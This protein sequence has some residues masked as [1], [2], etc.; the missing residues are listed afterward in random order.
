M[1]LMV[2]APAVAALRL[3]RR[4]TNLGD[5]PEGLTGSIRPDLVRATLKQ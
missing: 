1:W 5:A 2:Q 4:R 3:V